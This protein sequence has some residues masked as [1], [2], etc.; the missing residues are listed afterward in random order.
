MTGHDEWLARL[1][2]AFGGD[3]AGWAWTGEVRI[4]PD[5]RSKCA[6]GQHGLRYLFPW[7][8]DG[9]EE[10]I[11]GSVCVVNLPGVAPD[12]VE[13]VKGEVARRA[14]Q[15]RALRAE[16]REEQQL[17]AARELAEELRALYRRLDERVVQLAARKSSGAAMTSVEA[18]LLSNEYQHDLHEEGRVAIRGLGIK[19]PAGRI[20]KM[21]VVKAKL[22][23]HLETEPT[24]E[25]HVHG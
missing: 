2:A 7:R 18:R 15:D 12:Q 22:L 23:R 1:L 13:K 25:V 6:C 5:A 16:I 17:V 8:K 9:Q 20:R 14:E 4:D 19:T 24:P 21:L 3:L 11:T 10:V